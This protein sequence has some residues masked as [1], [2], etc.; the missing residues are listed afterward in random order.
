V[1]VGAVV[2]ALLGNQ[3][4]VPVLVPGI[5][6]GEGTAVN[7]PEPPT[8]IPIS[9][10]VTDG[11]SVTVTVAVVG[12]LGHPFNVYVTVYVVTDAGATAMD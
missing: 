10:K 8:Q 9:A 6:A 5:G 3:V 7:V 4:Y 11:G 1:N 12:A 2:T